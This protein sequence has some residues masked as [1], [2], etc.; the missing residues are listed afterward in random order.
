MRDAIDL[1]AFP[2][3][4]A[5]TN[6]H[7]REPSTTELPSGELFDTARGAEQGDGFGTVQ[8]GLTLAAARAPALAAAS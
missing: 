1:G 7:H 5:W 2:E 3:I 8:A 4:A 6:R